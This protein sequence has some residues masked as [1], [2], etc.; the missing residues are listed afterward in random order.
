M[1]RAEEHRRIIDKAL[2]CGYQRG[3]KDGKRAFGN[4]RAP[5]T[6]LRGFWLWRTNDATS[7]ASAGG[8][9]V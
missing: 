6:W 3:F 1:D 5:K 8:Q 7:P 9:R 2:A 4:P